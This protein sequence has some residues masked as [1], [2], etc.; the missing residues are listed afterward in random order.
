MNI[1]SAIFYV[2]I[3]IQQMHQ[4]LSTEVGKLVDDEII[5]DLIE[6]W[7]AI[8]FPLAKSKFEADQ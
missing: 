4:I 3:C 5:D 2:F 1:L 8:S 6:L 7:S